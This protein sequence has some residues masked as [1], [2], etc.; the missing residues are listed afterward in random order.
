M[1]S[2]LLRFTHLVTD[3]KF[4]SRPSSCQTLFLSIRSSNAK[5]PPVDET[6]RM[7]EKKLEIHV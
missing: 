1:L 2:T 6:I 7:T 4:Q 3:M 5:T